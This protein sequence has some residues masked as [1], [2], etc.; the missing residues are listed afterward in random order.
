MFIVGPNCMNI[1]TTRKGSGDILRKLKRLI[2][3]LVCA[4]ILINTLPQFALA[5]NNADGTC[6]VTTNNVYV[7]VENLT[8]NFTVPEINETSGQSNRGQTTQVTI[9]NLKHRG[10]YLIVATNRTG[11]QTAMR[12]NGNALATETVEVKPADAM[13][14][15]QYISTRKNA[16]VWT[17]YKIENTAD[18]DKNRE[19]NDWAF[20]ANNRYLNGTT[21]GTESGN[22]STT[23]RNNY[24]S[25]YW[26]QQFL[27]LNGNAWTST[28]SSNRFGDAPAN[29]T[30]IYFYEE[31]S[32]TSTYSLSANN[33][34]MNLNDTMSVND[35]V[36]Q[37]KL[38][39]KDT[40][41]NGL[42]GSYTYSVV[43]GN[44]SV[45][46]LSN[47]TLTA[48]GSGTAKVRV[49]Y[50]WGGYWNNDNSVWTEIDVVVGVPHYEVDIR[51]GDTSKSI[52]A[53]KNVKANDTVILNAVAFSGNYINS[54]AV[55]SWAPTD[56]SIGKVT[57]NDDGTVTFTFNGKEGSTV[58]LATYTYEKDGK[59]I[60]VADQVTITASHDAHIF[61][62][63]GTNDFPEYPDE[64]SVRL[65]KTAS[66]VGNFNQTGLVEVELSMTG[67]PFTTNAGLDIVLM[68]DE[69][70]SMTDNRRSATIEA[71]RVFLEQVVYDVNGNFTGNRIYIGSFQGGNPAYANQEQ[72]QFR[73]NNFTKNEDNGFQVIDSA[74]E[75]DQLVST[76]RTELTRGQNETQ[77]Y[78]TEYAKSLQYCYDL[79]ARTKTT[80][81]KQFCIF[82]SDGIP[83]AYQGEKTLFNATTTNNNYIGI[84]DMFDVTNYTAENATVTRDM[85]ANGNDNT[86]YEYE[87]YSSLMKNNGVTVF[88][89]G[90]GLLDKNSSWSNASARACEQVATIM[91]NDIS[92]P[93]FER[94]RQRDTGS[95][96]SK[97]NDYFFSVQDQNAAADMGAVFETIAQKI[98]DAARDVKVTDQI[99][100]EYTMVFEPP[101][102]YIADALNNPKFHID[103]LNY[104]LIPVYDQSGE[105]VDYKRTDNPT[106]IMKVYMGTKD[107][108]IDGKIV[109]DCYY[110]VDEA[111]E[112]FA[113]PTFVQTAVGT[114]FY[115]TTDPAKC[116]SHNG[117][118]V[119]G[120]DGKVYYFDSTGVSAESTSDL[121]DW[122]NLISGVYAFG[123]PEIITG[124]NDPDDN[125]EDKTVTV[126]R[127]L[128]IATPYFVY[129]AA[130]RELIW[131][132]EKLDNKEVALRY[133]LYLESATIGTEEEREPGTYPTNEEATL[134]YTNFQNNKVM[135]WFPEP[136][137]TWN[138]AQVTY[139]FYLVNEQGKPVNRAGRVVPFSEAVYVTDLRTINVV[140]TG[141]EEQKSLGAE[142]LAKD[143]VPDVYQ[144]YDNTAAYTIHAFGD[145]ENMDQHNHF[146]IDGNTN[147]TYVFNSKSDA[148]KYTT[149][150]TYASINDI[151]CKD[152]NVTVKDLGN[153]NYEWSYDGKLEQFLDPDNNDQPIYKFDDANQPYTI[154]WKQ[155]DT[156][157]EDGFNFYDTTVAFAVKWIPSLAPD[158]VVIDYGLDVMIDI[159]TN[160]MGVAEPVGLLSTAP[161]DVNMNTGHIIDFNRSDLSQYL[162]FGTAK[163]S[164]EGNYIR[165]HLYRENGMQLNGDYNFYYVSAVKYYSNNVLVTEYM[166]TKVR[167]IP[168]TTM[169]YEE[170]FADY[171]TNGWQSE[172]SISSTAVQDVDRPGFN[173]IS[174]SNDANNVYGY[175]SHYLNC[176][177]YSLNSTK[178]GGEGDVA[179]FTFNGTGFD[180]IGRTDQ[181]TACIL[182]SIE[183]V[184][185]DGEDNVPFTFTG[186]FMR[187]NEKVSVKGDSIFVDTYYE[188]VDGVN[189]IPQVPVVT[190][191]G[192]AYDTYKVSIKV[193][194]SKDAG[195][196]FYH[197]GATQFYLDAVRIYDPVNF[198]SSDD[199]IGKVYIMDNEWCPGYE[200]FRNEI[201][202]I[203]G[204]SAFSN[205]TFIDRMGKISDISTYESWG[206]NNE[207]YLAPGQ[208]ITLKIDPTYLYTKLNKAT[209][210][211]QS[212]GMADMQLGIKLVS[213]SSASLTFSNSNNL[214]RQ[215]KIKSTSDLNFSIK[216]LYNN[217]TTLTIE[218]N[219]GGV[220]A[221]TT[222]KVTLL[223]PQTSETY[224]LFHAMTTN[225]VPQPDYVEEPASIPNDLPTAPHEVI[226][227]AIL[228]IKEFFAAF[229]IAVANAIDGIS[230]WLQDVANALF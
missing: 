37:L 88:T 5:V 201:L 33:I 212:Q 60:T 78:G 29:A 53:K 77:R 86:I 67:V 83:N 159:T 179:T 114:M 216:D 111:G 204:D 21:T 47:N 228:S 122:Y 198:R 20:V 134:A 44:N 99:T 183:P 165:F 80:S 40:T 141:L 230:K 54:D 149:P 168:A 22:Y 132:L 167:V 73:I 191:R 227:G 127:D 147:T 169:Y 106:E 202:S 84:I 39:G 70:N 35:I 188:T 96:V 124:R 98:L 126:Y 121:G 125:I 222:M 45:I 211:G 117:V 4:V 193:I 138:G 225:P 30:K 90:L 209:A 154:V 58:L 55:I 14:P 10:N 57:T 19:D 49:T 146:K 166:Y 79:L 41:T 93:A 145:E 130:T 12:L 173:S 221:L 224:A 59:S 194:K 200:E 9:P 94:E 112:P 219:S 172:G 72:H 18:H 6:T 161:A 118:T 174:S 23:V 92:G 207:F 64:G 61:P 178:L 157:V 13:V 144:L 175:D 185:P 17:A 109:E 8:V 140:W 116:T 153:G 42:N 189:A 177:Q 82:M 133:Y 85:T 171:T 142:L 62:S 155:S 162:D 24:L 113:T 199:N 170:D 160:D 163:A 181:M 71:A 195:S 15:R 107:M 16:A 226:S 32:I 48:I 139:V 129:N 66:A 215:Y 46:T 87:K 25:W 50:S 156:Q 36:R 56:E 205:F 197:D 214:K 229:I 164:L 120:A 190:V 203:Y 158:E 119:T 148:N 74:S 192:L 2:S 101:S 51:E 152:Y 100:D 182:L 128:V 26:A 136:Q 31:T 208:S 65:D 206:P 137:M 68:L 43:P 28:Q 123:S 105:I 104:E 103:V 217:A 34:Q 89:V 110:A 97:L 184:K 115:W 220:V 76:I 102:P 223:P 95:T 108:E 131:T 38:D 210:V 135:Q 176:E 52:I 27:R 186:T 3:L 150:N 213:G 143:I 187:G 7:L 75:L 63:D 91:L 1:C 81:N 151:K 180:L 218:N 196:S 11:D 69:S